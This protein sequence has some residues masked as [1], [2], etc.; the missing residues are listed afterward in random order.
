[1]IQHVFQHLQDKGE[2]GIQRTAE[3]PVPS[4]VLL[5]INLLGV[6]ICK[7]SPAV[8]ALR[9]CQALGHVTLILHK[10][11]LMSAALVP[12]IFASLPH[13]E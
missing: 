5:S 1:M 9:E 4:W 12:G 3:H 10:P 6:G 8:Q 13:Q 11:P 2:A 7:L